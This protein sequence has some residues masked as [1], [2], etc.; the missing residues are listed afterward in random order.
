L[1]SQFSV[2]YERFNAV[3]GDAIDWQIFLLFLGIGSFGSVD[4]L[5]APN[6]STEAIIVILG[7]VEYHLV[8]CSDKILCYSCQ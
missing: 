5:L 6:L 8:L 1:A 7:N 4:E 2:S 3:F